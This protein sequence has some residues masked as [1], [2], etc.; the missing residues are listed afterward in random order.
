MNSDR[1]IRLCGLALVL[2]A[3]GLGGCS[4]KP[5]V[6]ADALARERDELRER[7][8]QLEDEIRNRDARLAELASQNDTLNAQLAE[9][10]TTPAP[11]ATGGGV[12][13]TGFEGI[14]G[15]GSGRNASGEVVVD[16]AGDVLFDPGSVVLKTS[17]RRTLDRVAD[18][19]NARYSGNRIRVEGHADSDPIRKSK[20]KDN[21]ELS[22]QRA[23][24]V[25]RY[26]AQRGVA[27]TRMYSAAFGSDEPRGSKSRSRR[28]E[29]VILG[30]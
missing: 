24:A 21:E 5:K 25:E 26:L 11:V 30:S 18:V 27:R 8:A 1:W 13:D 10:R 6:D 15:V 28:V 14:P 19:L 12:G 9:A 7:N 2:A 3:G 23:L 20:W 4:G 16:V 17:S 29:I 22:A